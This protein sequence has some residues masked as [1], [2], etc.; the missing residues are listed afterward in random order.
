MSKPLIALVNKLKTFQF[1]RNGLQ[2]QNEICESSN[3]RTQ[4]SEEDQIKN[5]NVVVTQK[6][7]GMISFLKRWSFGDLSQETN[8]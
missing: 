6:L 1:A 2:G 5:E 7:H 8:I 4:K 3:L